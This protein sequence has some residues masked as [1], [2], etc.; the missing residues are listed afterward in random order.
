MKS[1]IV[2][3]PWFARTLLGIF[4]LKAYIDGKRLLLI[5]LPVSNEWVQKVQDK[6]V[7]KFEKRLKKDFKKG[8]DTYV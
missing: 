6:A 4:G 7:A 3:P 8:V 5:Q 1:K 2:E